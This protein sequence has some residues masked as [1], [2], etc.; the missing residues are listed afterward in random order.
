MMQL[1][2]KTSLSRF[3]TWTDFVAGVSSAGL[4]LPQALAYSSIANLP[5]Q[6]GIIGL[7]AGLLCY[8]FLGTSRFALV[9]PTSSAAVVL[10]AAIAAVAGGNSGLQL[11]ISGGLV[12]A[13]GV[14]FLLAA[15]I[16]MGNVTDFVARPVLRGFTFGMA[17]VIIIKQLGTVLN[18]HPKSDNL[19]Y[20]I[21]EL[22][23]QF[24]NWHY[25]SIAV[26]VLTIICLFVFGKIKNFP[27]GIIVILVG[28]I[29]SALIDLPKFGVLLIGSIS[30][31]MMQFK[32]P[33]LALEEWQTLFELSLAMVFIL[34][35]ESYGSIRSFAIKHG[36]AM[37]PNRDLFALGISN[38]VSGLFQ[39]M[40][41][42]AGYSA[43]AANEAC[44]AKTRM[45]GLFAMLITLV[46]LVTALPYIELI[47]QAVL[48]G[49]VIYTMFFLL[50]PS[51][52]RIYFSWEKDRLI[53]FL[54]VLA[55]LF[56]GVLHGLLIAVGI[57][58]VI[59]LKQIST[60]TLSELGRLGQTHDFVSTTTFPEA[61]PIPGILILRPDQGLFFAN[62]ERVLQQARQ[63][64]LSYS[65][66]V[67]TIILSLELT[68]DL[69]TTSLEAF[70]DF[71]IF[72]QEQ[73]KN[74]VLARLKDLV[75]ETLQFSLYKEF[76]DVTMSRLSVERAVH[77]AETKNTI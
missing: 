30:V 6:T 22:M 67:H 77:L 66:P 71:F 8:G 26:A 43:T 60:S 46:V 54:S 37:M 41:V 36:D 56:L 57:S 64:L 62:T 51:S 55:V 44:G 63:I 45:S 25:P 73:N 18:V 68:N 48:A 14:F 72:L 27:G 32:I 12:I 15:L 13:T 34:Y 75:F 53:A 70:Q 11:V 23:S 10:A 21:M 20:F 58:I 7:F 17:I 76:P 49:I 16:R 3:F 24:E 74:I 59:M 38:L 61:K 42:G 65:E 40:P 52:F 47:P 9:S 4:L 28:I 35:A 39:G 50:K 5:A 31:E 1:S 19:F 29:S 33:V 69:D 2:K